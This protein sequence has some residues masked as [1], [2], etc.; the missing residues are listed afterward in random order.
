MDHYPSQT[1]NSNVLPYITITHWGRLRNYSTYYL[2]YSNPWLCLLLICSTERRILFGY[3]HGIFN[4]GGF[5]RD[6]DSALFQRSQSLSYMKL[7]CMEFWHIHYQHFMVL[8]CI[9][10]KYLPTSLWWCIVSLYIVSIYQVYISETYNTEEKRKNYKY[11][12]VSW[13]CCERLVLVL[14]ETLC[15]T[16]WISIFMMKNI[17]GVFDCK[18]T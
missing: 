15:C 4:I 13:F 10:L 5:Q 6:L 7:Q 1:W 18:Y 14:P 12:F 9:G 17:P 11:D 3:T 2:Y 16:T 8:I